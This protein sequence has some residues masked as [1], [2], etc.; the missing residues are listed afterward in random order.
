MDFEI[1]L[2]G[3]HQ[4]HEKDF[5]IDRQGG[6]EEWIFT[7]FESPFVF[8]TQNGIETGAAGQCVVTAPH[9]PQ[10]HGPVSGAESG[11]VNSW[12]HARGQFVEALISRYQIP[13]NR[14]FTLRDGR[15]TIL[16]LEQM[17]RE[18]KE[19]KAYWKDQLRHLFEGLMISIARDQD[20]DRVVRPAAHQEAFYNVR[21][22][23]LT[24][25]DQKWSI[26]RLCEMTNLSQS[27]FCALYQKFFRVSPM[28]DLL[29]KRM[30]E[31]CKL[32]LSTH[33]SVEQVA[34]E[35]GFSNI[36]YFSNLFKKRMGVSPKAYRE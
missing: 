15:E 3:T 16:R 4:S 25:F 8:L 14:I 35:T 30:E 27:R 1:L 17:D 23:M 2:L 11:F 28:E 29:E 10:Y 19:K 34:E 26:R 22:Q 21:N 5:Y 7:Y 18:L 33:W 13:V 24:N 36:Y 32:L 12:F 20:A 6:T 9:F 31:A